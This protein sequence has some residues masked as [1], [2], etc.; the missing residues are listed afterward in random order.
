MNRLSI[1][2]SSFDGYSDLW[3]T[4]FV[5]FDK[6][7]ENC[8]YEIYLVNNTKLF[9]HKKVNVI[10][11]GNEIS[12]FDRTIRSLQEINTEYILF[13]LEDYYISK[14]INEM[15]VEEI[16]DFIEEDGIY[17]YRLSPH[18]P[19]KRNGKYSK[20]K[21]GS[22]YPISLQPG[23]WK[24]EKLIEILKKSTHRH[25]GISKIILIITILEK[26]NILPE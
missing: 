15:I 16:L 22:K 23:I 20:V 13:M 26:K 9:E 7:W 14:P 12:W 11:T 1:Y 2:I 24:R 18:I 4:F 3:D 25:L 10:H 21:V 6:Y 19:P 8:S 5:I 17:Y